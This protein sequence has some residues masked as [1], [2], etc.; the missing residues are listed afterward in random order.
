MNARLAPFLIFS[1]ALAAGCSQPG[2]PTSP[3]SV[4]SSAQVAT[5]PGAA[6][7]AADASSAAATKAVPFKG[8]LEGTY[9][10]S[11]EPP[12]VSV[13]V[14]AQ[15]NAT[16]LG[17]FTFDSQHVVNFV[18]LTGAGTAELTAANGDKLMTNLTGIATPQD[19]PGVFF[20]VETLTITGGTGGLR[21]P[22]GN[23]LSNACPFQAAPQTARR[24]ARSKGRSRCRAGALKSARLDRAVLR[25]SRR[26][27]LGPQSAPSR[28]S[29]G[30]ARSGS[31]PQEL[32]IQ[33]V[34]GPRF[35]PGHP[36]R[37][38]DGCC[39]ARWR[40]ASCHVGTLPISCPL[41]ATSGGNGRQKATQS[42]GEIS[43]FSYSD[44]TIQ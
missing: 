44:C 25:A 34:A 36:W 2:S 21:G 29:L 32:Q 26:A 43:R 12:L 1:V 16:H 31:R 19:T 13:H 10:G 40:T 18:D 35:E 15:G 9:A 6:T 17:R 27:R 38:A 20:I 4:A 5:T 41:D 8:R 39:T 3:T 24:L 42:K 23:S 11:G 28:G 33:R 14:E 22:P 7:F 37:I 30:T